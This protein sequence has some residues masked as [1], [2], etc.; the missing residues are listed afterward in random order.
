MENFVRFRY[1]A[2][3]L[4]VFVITGVSGYMGIE[5]WPF[6]DSVYMTILTFTTVGYS[7]VR[8]LSSGG[9]VFT[10]LL[11]L[12]GVS[13]MLYTLTTAVQAVVEEE[14]LRGFLRR[15]TMESKL[16]RMRDH[17]I[18]CGFGRVGRSAAAAFARESL[19][20][21]VIDRD[22]DAILEADKMRLAYIQSDA[23]EDESLR[24]AHVD[25]A[26]GLVAALGS[27]SDNVFV[28]LSAR[29]MNPDVHIVAR[30]QSEE[31][32]SNLLR[33]GANRVVSPHEIGGVR[34]AMASTRPLA[35]DFLDS[36]LRPSEENAQ[37]LTEVM[38]TPES[39][40]AN[41]PISESCAGKG[42]H[43]LAIQR[44]GAIIVNPSSETKCLPGD[45]V[46][47]VGHSRVLDILEGKGS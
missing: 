26:R 19:S 35:I 23:T 6:L 5:G 20:V 46:V 2:L 1:A 25:R 40:L 27:D 24:G 28:T 7:E 8:P 47:L 11:M 43:V 4:A 38:V 45:S 42:V 31:S 34:M 32:H 41:A 37:R 44:D 3:A 18:I 39:A 12:G 14:L 29:G 36:V 22:A 30:A 33:A 21:V 9:R 16:S 17:F 10:T 15:R 13:T